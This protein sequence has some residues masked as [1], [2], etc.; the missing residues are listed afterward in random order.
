MPTR[1]REATKPATEL[2][3]D[4]EFEALERWDIR[5][6]ERAIAASGADELE[7]YPKASIREERKLDL[8]WLASERTIEREQ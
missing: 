3:A 2:T 8:Y 5:A 6:K 1:T 4:V 7:L